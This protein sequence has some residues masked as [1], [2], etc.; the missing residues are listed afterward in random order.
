MPSSPKS[1]CPLD[2]LA[3][4]EED[5]DQYASNVGDNIVAMAAIIKLYIEMRILWRFANISKSKRI[6][7]AA[8]QTI[9][10]G[11]PN[12]MATIEPM[13]PTNE[14]VPNRPVAH[15]TS[16]NGKKTAKSWR[17]GSCSSW[18]LKGPKVK[19]KTA[20]TAQKTPVMATST[21][22]RYV[23]L[24]IFSLSNTFLHNRNTLLHKN[25]SARPK[26]GPKKR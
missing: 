24:L 21:V 11:P 19:F 12:D 8:K 16:N 18:K 9:R 10:G 1:Q 23:L 25:F 7:E 17:I 14:L 20:K 2:R 26:T 15:V 4:R 3:G 6:A 5:A 22:V 13:M